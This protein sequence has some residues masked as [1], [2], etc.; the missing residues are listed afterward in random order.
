[1]WTVKRDV[2]W[3]V[4]GPVFETDHGTFALSY[5]GQGEVRQPNQYMAMNKATDLTSWRAAMA[6]QA[7]PSIN[8]I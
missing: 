7:L 8:F 2:L 4:H 1:L 5:A 3:S 6:I